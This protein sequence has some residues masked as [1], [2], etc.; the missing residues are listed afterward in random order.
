VPSAVKYDIGVAG[1]AA[2]AVA[3]ARI[4]AAAALPLI[5]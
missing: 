5:G 3:F 1:F 4:A 2:G